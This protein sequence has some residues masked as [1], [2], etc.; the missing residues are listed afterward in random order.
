LKFRSICLLAA[1]V[2]GKRV[3]DREWRA[4]ESRGDDRRPSVIPVRI[5]G[6]SH[7][8]PQWTLGGGHGQRSRSFCSRAH[9][10]RD[11]SGGS[12]SRFFRAYA[13]Y[14]PARIGEIRKSSQEY[15]PSENAMDDQKLER[16]SMPGNRK[17]LQ[18]SGSQTRI[19][20]ILRLPGLDP[21]YR[22]KMR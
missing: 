22:P 21:G 6:S 13:G 14:G 4:A 5:Q 16:F 15:P 3:P 17:P 20:S 10:R 7:Q 11:A 2:H 12:S 18:P 8:S 9:Y 19:E 1:V